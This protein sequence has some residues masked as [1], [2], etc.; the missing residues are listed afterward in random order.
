MIEKTVVKK[1]LL[2]KTIPML[3]KMYLDLFYVIDESGNLVLDESS[4][5][6]IHDGS[7]K[8]ACLASNIYKEWLVLSGIGK[9]KIMLSKVTKEQVIGQ[10]LH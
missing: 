1:S 6:V 3:S 5:F 7:E 8:V 2:F 4:N 10:T 9:L